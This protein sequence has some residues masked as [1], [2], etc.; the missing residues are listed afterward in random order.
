MIEVLNTIVQDLPLSGLSQVNQMKVKKLKS[1]LTL[2]KADMS[3]N[4]IKKIF[5]DIS[6]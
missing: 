6:I 3:E 2:I 1:E 5:L 4:N